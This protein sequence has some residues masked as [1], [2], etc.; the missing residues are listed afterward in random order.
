MHVVEL[1]R[2]KRDGETL[3][4]AELAFLVAGAATNSVPEYQLSA[5]LM[6][7]CWRGLKQKSKPRRGARRSSGLPT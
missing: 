3:S 5:W 2:K 7:V 4:D 1:I 6:A